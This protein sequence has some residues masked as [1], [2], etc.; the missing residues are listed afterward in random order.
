MLVV[1][2]NTTFKETSYQ[3][4]KDVSHKATNIHSDAA[5]AKDSCVADM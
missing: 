1:F 3:H 4:I 5:D 2:S